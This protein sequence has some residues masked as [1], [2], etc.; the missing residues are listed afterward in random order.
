MRY[1]NVAVPV[2]TLL[3]AAC[4][5]SENPSAEGVAANEAAVTEVAARMDQYV[6][7][8]K[9]SDMAGLADYFAADAMISEPEVRATGSEMLKI[10][11]DFMKANDLLALQVTAT[12]RAA[13]D[14]GSVVYE[15]GHYT[16]KYKAKDGKSPETNVR[17]N[18]AIRWI[19]DAESK[20]KI[21][22]FNTT[23]APAESVQVAPAVAPV[24]PVEGPDVD[25]ATVTAQVTEAMKGFFTQANAGDAEGMLKFC[26]D[27]FQ[28]YEPEL[29]VMSK[30]AFAPALGEFLKASAL[31]V[32]LDSDQV[33]V[34][35]DGRVAYQLGNYQETVTPKDGKSAAVNYHNTFIARW[36]RSA[37]G[38]WVADRILVT[39]LPKDGPR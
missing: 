18:Y 14:G 28:L 9:A 4:G 6:A 17:G 1:S 23:T 29:Q 15:F 26:A 27:D 21:H 11:A 25:A 19:K 36:K 20:W 37:D 38:S 5:A 32:T 16:E 3:V 31:S 24:A 13:H 35:D 34:H 10:G 8:I 33:F 30:A 7:T 2:F 12:E 22:R 39:P